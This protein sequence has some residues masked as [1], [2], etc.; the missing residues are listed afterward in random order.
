MVVL[1]KITQSER[2][3]TA[4][5]LGKEAAENN[6][7]AKS[8]LLAYMSHEIRTP[9]NGIMSMTELILDTPLTSGRREYPGRFKI[10]VDSF[11]SVIKNILDSN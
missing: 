8:N 2:V 10:S 1:S 11:M 3:E 4:L 7:R 6:N 9:M 5:H